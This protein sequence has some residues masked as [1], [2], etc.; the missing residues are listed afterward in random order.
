MDPFEYPRLRYAFRIPA[1]IGDRSRSASDRVRPKCATRPEAL[2]WPF[3]SPLRAVEKQLLADPFPADIPRRR[4]RMTLRNTRVNLDR[5]R[6]RTAV[7]LAAA[8]G[9]VLTLG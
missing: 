3:I 9:A 1:T 2:R 6:P 4:W 5:R 8:T 7:E